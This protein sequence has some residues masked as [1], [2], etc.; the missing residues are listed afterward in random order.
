MDPLVVIITGT[1][2][3]L[4]RS[5]A[6]HF[7]SKNNQVVGCSRSS[8]TITN[9]RYDHTNLDL[10]NEK[11][12]RSWIRSVRLKFGRIDVLICNAAMVQSALFLAVTPGDLMESFLR[13]NISSVFY[14]LREVSKQ[15]ISHGKGRIIAISSTTT[16]V[17]QEGTSIYSA[18][19][20]AVTEMIKILAKEVSGRGVT[21]NVIAPAMMKTEAS[22]DLAASDEWE[23]EMVKKQTIQRVIT[24]DEMCHVAD[25][26]ISP[27]SSAIT[28]QVIYIGLSN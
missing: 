9:E 22:S 17:H 5:L 15:M 2:R 6:E 26:L 12:V 13:N 20:S 1:S 4:G 21:C 18:T 28:G 8:A 16:A 24:M 23:Q 3:G 11:E 19:K 25:F 27:L 7:L 14:A 10:S